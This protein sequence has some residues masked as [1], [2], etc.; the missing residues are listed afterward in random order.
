MA[1]VDVVHLYLHEIPLHA[2]GQQVVE[3]LDGPVERPPE[4]ADA[5]RLALAQQELQYAVVDE[6]LSEGAQAAAAAHRVQQ[7]VVQVVDLQLFERVAVEGQRIFAR[8]V[9]EVRHL[10]GD[11]FSVGNSK[12][13]P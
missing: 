10:R 1:P 2:H 3:D 5:S 7:V 13:Y 12:T 9:R 8:G 4:V 6:A 11:A